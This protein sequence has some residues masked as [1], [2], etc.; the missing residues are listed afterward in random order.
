MN[1]E[2]NATYEDGVL[3]PDQQLPL[4]N[5]QRVRVRVD[6]AATRAAASFGLLAWKGDPAELD[7]LLGPGNHPWA[8]DE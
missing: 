2:V 7:L 1:L 3:K 8:V 5:G 4:E 6:P